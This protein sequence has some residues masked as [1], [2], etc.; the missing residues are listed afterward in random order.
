MMNI[1]ALIGVPVEL[2][3]LQNGMQAVVDGFVGTFVVEPS[4]EVC[5]QTKARM[6]EEAEKQQLLQQMKGAE[7]R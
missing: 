5:E 2:D 7:K 4:K 6:A 1:P 3:A